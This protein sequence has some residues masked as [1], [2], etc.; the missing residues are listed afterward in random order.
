MACLTTICFSYRLCS[1]VLQDYVAK[2]SRLLD[3]K[4]EKLELAQGGN[5][6]NRASNLTRN[7]S[8]NANKSQK[9]NQSLTQDQEDIAAND[10]SIDSSKTKLGVTDA[11]QLEM[12][13]GILV[14]QVQSLTPII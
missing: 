2:E 12:H 4:T 13:E 8:F 5:S 14:K 10:A 6:S 7:G 3:L 9:S 11:G 1:S